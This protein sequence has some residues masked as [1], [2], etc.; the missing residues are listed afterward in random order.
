SGDLVVQEQLHTREKPFM[1]LE[2]EKSFRN[3]SNLIT[4]QRIHTGE[5]PYMCGECGK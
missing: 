5:W 4:H 2:C 1:C 3:S